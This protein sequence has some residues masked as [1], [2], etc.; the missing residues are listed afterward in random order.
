MGQGFSCHPGKHI[1]TWLLR[2]WD[3]SSGS[4]ESEGREAKQLG[5]FSGEGGTEKATGNGAQALSLWRRRLSGVKERDPFQEDAVGL[6]RVEEQQVL[7]ATTVLQQRQERDVVV[8]LSWAAELHLNRSLPAPPQTERGENRME[9]AQG[10]REGHGDHS[11]MIVTGKRG[12]AEPVP[13]QPG[14]APAGALHRPR[15][16]PGHIHLLHRGLLHGLQRGDLQHSK[17][18]HITHG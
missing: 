13:V 1:V 17:N 12:S 8:F 11:T 15:P 4:L 10:L 6:L 3:N 5:S 16:P 9:R 2:C 14:P 7:A 18:L